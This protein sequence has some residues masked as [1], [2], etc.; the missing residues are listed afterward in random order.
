M[1]YPCVPCGAPVEVRD[2][3]WESVTGLLVVSAMEA[4]RW[5]LTLV[6]VGYRMQEGSLLNAVFSLYCVCHSHS[7]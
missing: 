7:Q 5:F 4:R 1:Y 3:V 6:E 2:S